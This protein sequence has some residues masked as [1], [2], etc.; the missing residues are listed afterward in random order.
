MPTPSLYRDPAGSLRLAGADLSDVATATGTPSYAYD[1]GAMAAAARGIQAAFD[2]RPHLVAYALKANTAGA[3]VRTFAAEGCG[4][5]IVSGAE[6]RVALACG[7]PPERIVYSGVAKMDDEIDLALAT[8][9]RGIGA[10]LVESVEEIARVEAR[11]RAAG[12]RARVGIRV[13]PSLDLEGATHA[14]I[15]TGHDRA[16]FGVPRGDAARAA[17]LVEVS[18]HLQL[19][20]ITAHVG[21][22]FKSTGPYVESAQVLFGIVKAMREAG[23][24]RS[25]E[26]VDTGGGF[27]VDY[28]GEA[29]VS[30]PALPEPADFV[31]AVRA[32]QREHGL[33]DLALYAEPGRC[34][35][36]AFGVLVA[37]VVQAKV[38][39]N[40]RW[41]MIDAG[42]NDL[43]RP[44]LYQARHRIVPLRA[45]AGAPL[46]GEGAGAMPWRV[47][48][49]VCESSDDF[50]DHLLPNEAPAH[51]AILDTGAYGYTMASV[52]N[53]RQLPVEAFLRDGRIVG[54]TERPSIEAWAQ[55]RARAG[56]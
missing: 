42:M 6:L 34:L 15:A 28:S 55:A 41:L 8:G 35:V 51:V 49:P 38:G 54:Q 17:D 27:A 32:A 14:H 56:V 33:D 46:S 9:P 31:R 43:L 39:A 1:L 12:R 37:R 5:D 3:V 53:G 44:A 26:F 20:G 19:V 50:G 7:M 52:Y 47:V 40:R 18:P 30:A 48:G 29:G 13:N 45:A 4:A 23:R 25:L 16:K 11:A 21:S 24:G 2:G 22:H 36:A 10:V